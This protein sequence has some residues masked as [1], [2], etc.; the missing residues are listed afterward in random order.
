MADY[1]SAQDMAHAQ[2]VADANQRAAI[3][4][5]IAEGYKEKNV[6]VA[7]SALDAAIEGAGVEEE[8]SDGEDDEDDA[9]MR[10]FRAKRLQGLISF[11]LA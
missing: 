7:T 1:K 4:T 5:R 3:L 9:F 11:L 2:R 10:E 6:V 8:D